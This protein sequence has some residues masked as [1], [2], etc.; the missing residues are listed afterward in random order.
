MSTPHAPSFMHPLVAGY[1]FAAPE[2]VM[3]TQVAGGRARYALEWDRGVQVFSIACLMTPAQFSV[4][5]A[6]FHLTIKKG[7]VSFLLPLNSGFGVADHLV[8]MLPG[9]YSVTELDSKHASV[10]FQ[11][12]AESQA[13]LLDEEAAEAL[14]VMY[15][16]YGQNVHS[17]FRR[18]ATFA[19]SDTNALDFA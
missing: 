19:N 14:V 2:G 15:D 9:T 16:L 8:D 1:S 10:A 13:Y 11:V 6:F 18:L 5:N 17:F 7:S 4:W 12:E 3:R